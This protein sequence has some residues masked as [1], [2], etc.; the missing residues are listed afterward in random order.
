MRAHLPLPRLGRLLLGAAAIAC[1]APDGRLQAQ[2]D[3]QAL[4]AARRAAAATF[5]DR[6]RPEAERLAAVE[7]IG[8]PDD[9]TAAA[10]LAVGADRSQSDA[11]RWQALRRVQYGEPY[12]ATVLAILRSPQDGGEELDAN[13]IKDLSQK[14][15]F[16]IPPLHQQRIQT[17]ERQLLGDRRDKVRLYA[18]RALVA[19]HDQVALN[20]LVDSLRRGQN[21]PIPL[22]DAIELLDDDGA[23]NYIGVLRPYLG[24]RNP[25]VQARAARALALDP[26]SRP[27]IVELARNPGSPE[28]VRLN[29]L[30][31]LARED[32][33]FASYAIPIVEDPQ[34]DPD[35]RYAAMHSFVG[36]LNY[37][38][39][40][41][42]DQVRFAQA[43]E[44]LAGDQR[45]ATSERG[46]EV[47]EGARQLHLY[48]KQAFPEIKKHYERP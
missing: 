12:L 24:N 36:R 1:L 38:P 41:P 3:P 43:V 18:Y 34:E 14:T 10:L 17:V 19:N 46:A 47:R 15:A 4:R 45:L 31:G 37:A 40:D 16:T 25:Q 32:G 42:A 9:A 28:E 22:P 5:L 11:V 20:Q 7:E 2:T 27:K 29:A 13:L 48:L 33:R 30:R 35:V 44:K 21:V 39:V 26:E 8:Y 23:A 6:Q